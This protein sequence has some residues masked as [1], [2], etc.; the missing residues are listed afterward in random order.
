MRVHLFHRR[1]YDPTG[2]VEARRP[3]PWRRR[4]PDIRTLPAHLRRDLGL[5]HGRLPDDPDMGMTRR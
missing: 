1:P 2:A 3:S 4:G 5:D